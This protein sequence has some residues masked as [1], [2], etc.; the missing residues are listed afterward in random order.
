[1][2]NP[3]IEQMIT[4]VDPLQ[5]WII[6]KLDDTIAVFD[7]EIMANNICWNMNRRYSLFNDYR[8]EPFTMYRKNDQRN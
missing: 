5:I 2:M 8:V 4:N 6:Y 1:M 3:Y 7:D